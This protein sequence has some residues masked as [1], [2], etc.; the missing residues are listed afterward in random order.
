MTQRVRGSAMR[1]EARRGPPPPAPP[2]LQEEGPRLGTAPC[3]LRGRLPAR[4][5]TGQR[6]VETDHGDPE[7]PSR[8]TGAQEGRGAA[9]TAFRVLLVCGP[10][11]PRPGQAPPRRPGT[12]QPTRLARDHS[13]HHERDQ[14]G[15][16]P[17]S[18]KDQL[19]NSQPGG[20]L[21]QVPQGSPRLCSVKPE[22]VAPFLQRAGPR[23]Q[24]QRNRLLATAHSF[25]G[26]QAKTTPRMGLTR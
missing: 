26:D 9:S 18:L 21:P 15:R 7:G 8:R 22:C 6:V 17:S 19:Q 23:N 13:R 11:G 3:P 24:V 25:C 10:T 16:S 5:A 1:K 20:S 14:K 12:H 4:A 2:G